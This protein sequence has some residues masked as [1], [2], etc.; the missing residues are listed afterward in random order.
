MNE[1][2]GIDSCNE[3]NAATLGGNNGRMAAIREYA[4]DESEFGKNVGKNRFGSE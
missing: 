3:E 2:G 1:K 4:S